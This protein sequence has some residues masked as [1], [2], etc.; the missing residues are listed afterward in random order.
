MP[1]IHRQTLDKILAD[2]GLTPADARLV[3]LARKVADFV[4]GRGLDGFDITDDAQRAL[5]AEAVGVADVN[6]LMKA[7]ALAQ[8]A[9]DVVPI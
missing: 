1:V 9:G 8:A 4:K 2:A 3:P 6:V 7:L 5:L